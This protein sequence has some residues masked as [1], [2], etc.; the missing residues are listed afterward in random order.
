MTGIGS[1]GT[2]PLDAGFAT[3]L[4]GQKAVRDLAVVQRVVV[5]DLGIKGI[6]ARA[7]IAAGTHPVRCNRRLPRSDTPDIRDI[8]RAGEWINRRI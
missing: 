7:D 5:P 2:I 3:I 1:T 4:R 8:V 6:R